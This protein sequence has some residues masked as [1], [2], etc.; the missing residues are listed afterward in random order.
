MRTTDARII[1]LSSHGTKKYLTFDPRRAKGVID[2]SGED[3]VIVIVSLLSSVAR[4]LCKSSWLN[5][6][7]VSLLNA[8]GALPTGTECDNPGGSLRPVENIH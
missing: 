2:V 3:S 4:I 7:C 6:Y 1:S 5:E 8:V